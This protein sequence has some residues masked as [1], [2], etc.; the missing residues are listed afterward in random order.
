MARAIH[1]A[2]IFMAWGGFTYKFWRL[3]Q[4]PRT[5]A[6]VLFCALLFVFGLSMTISLPPIYLHLPW[7]STSPSLVRLVQQ[8]LIVVTGALA[9]LLFVYLLFPAGKTR[10]PVSRRLAL[11]GVVLV[12]M[13]T[14]FSLAPIGDDAEDF[15][16]AYASRPF[17]TEYLLVFLTYFALSLFDLSRLSFRY[18]RHAPEGLL[19]K[20]ITLLGI[21]AVPGFAYTVHKAG[22]TVASRLGVHLPWPEGPVSTALIGVTF[23]PFFAGATIAAWGPPIVSFRRKVGRFQVYREILPLW[24]AVYEVLPGLALLGAPGFAS[25]RALGRVWQIKFA[26]SA[27]RRP[28]AAPVIRPSTSSTRPNHRHRQ[29]PPGSRSPSN[30]FT[31]HG[32]DVRLYRCVIEILDSGFELRPY[33]DARVAELARDRGEKAGLDGKELESVVAAAVFATALRRKRDELKVPDAPNAPVFSA[34]TAEAEEYVRRVARA[35]RR[36]P[37]VAAV[38]AETAPVTV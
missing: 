12:A 29:E 22:Y 27:P 6:V 38:L 20:G 33:V 19:R 13:I 7:F 23:L 18:A 34:G 1:L 11:A 25:W 14:L 8:S 15:V 10:R 2:V 21:A 31:R 4:R 3:W 26:V 32:L 5:P 37:V 35:Y 24:S 36:S 30:R 9:Q 17:V 28:L 16:A